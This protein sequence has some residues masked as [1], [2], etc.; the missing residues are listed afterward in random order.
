MSHQEEKKEKK[1]FFFLEVVEGRSV[2][3][4]K[5]CP[6]VYQTLPILKA[7]SLS[8]LEDEKNRKRRR[9]T[10]KLNFD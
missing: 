6:H 9:K 2:R 10:Q 5:M 3:L 4:V 7:S 1:L 8:P